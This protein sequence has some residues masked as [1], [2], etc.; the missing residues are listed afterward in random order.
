M[1]M[2]SF[3]ARLR[4]AMGAGFIWLTSAPI[5]FSQGVLNISQPVFNAG[6]PVSTSGWAWQSIT[7]SQA[8]SLTSFAFQLNGAYNFTATVDLLTGVGTNNALVASTTGSAIRDAAGPYQGYYYLVAD[9]GSIDLSAGQYT[10]FLH[11]P[12]SS[13]QMVADM[14]DVYAGGKFVSNTYGDP[15]WDATFFTPTPTPEPGSVALI[16][17]GLACAIGYNTI[18]RRDVDSNG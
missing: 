12:S 6:I 18:K 4:V 17:A 7:V 16:I 13:F 10:V 1:K 15:G 5:A 11:N 9:F 14:S 8:S 3:S 2:I